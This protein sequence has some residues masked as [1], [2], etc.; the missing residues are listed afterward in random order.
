MY[1]WVFSWDENFGIHTL[2]KID[3]RRLRSS[4]LIFPHYRVEKQNLQVERLIGFEHLNEIMVQ[5]SSPT[6]KHTYLH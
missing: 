1:A 2:H 6:C 4:Q 5:N 3:M